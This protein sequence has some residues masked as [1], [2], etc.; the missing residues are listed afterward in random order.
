MS[1]NH[2]MTQPVEPIRKKKEV[3]QLP[4]IPVEPKKPFSPNL[5]TMLTFPQAVV[6]P[7]DYQI[8]TQQ[9]SACFGFVIAVSLI[10]TVS[11]CQW[12]KL[13]L[14]I[15]GGTPLFW[16]QEC[17]C[18]PDQKNDRCQPHGM[19]SHSQRQDFLKQHMCST[20][21]HSWWY[22]THFLPFLIGTFILSGHTTI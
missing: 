4:D 3:A 10:I 14:Y 9:L 21:K 11:L 1:W 19:W 16:Q 12:L 5:S 17:Q 2:I 7:L 8:T 20:H 22:P 6:H 15:P 13:Q 18:S